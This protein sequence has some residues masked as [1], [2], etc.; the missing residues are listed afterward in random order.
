[1]F[2]LEPSPRA[3]FGSKLRDVYAELIESAIPKHLAELMTRLEVAQ[4]DT[5]D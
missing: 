5:R 4:T 1:V 3:D 2:R